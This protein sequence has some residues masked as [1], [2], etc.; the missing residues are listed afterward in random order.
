MS[1][2]VVNRFQSTVVKCNNELTTDDIQWQSLLSK[3][4]FRQYI[5]QTKKKYF[6]LISE[7]FGCKTQKVKL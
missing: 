3:K 2:K 4:K 7:I 5:R 1:S 6:A